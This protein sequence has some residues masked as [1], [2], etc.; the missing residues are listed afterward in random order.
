[1]KRSVIFLGIIVA[2][3]IMTGC[4]KIEEEVNAVVYD[5]WTQWHGANEAKLASL[6]TDEVDFGFFVEEKIEADSK[7]SLAE[8]MT[9]ISASDLATIM[10]TTFTVIP[11]QEDAF[12]IAKTSVY[13]KYAVV[14]VNLLT[15]ADG[16]ADGVIEMLFHLIDTDEGWKICLVGLVGI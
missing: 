5:F 3:A 9:R 12:T 7:T 6:M 16:V 8:N 13:T 2:L 15:P 10:I 14:N 1:M 4:A 11:F